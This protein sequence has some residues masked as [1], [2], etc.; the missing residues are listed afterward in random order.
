MVR[1]NGL[2]ERAQP[3]AETEVDAFLESFS[4]IVDELRRMSPLCVKG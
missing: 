4:P 2:V 3:N 1:E